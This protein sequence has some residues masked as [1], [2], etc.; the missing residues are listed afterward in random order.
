MSDDIFIS[1]SSE[2][3]ERIQPIIQVLERRGWSVWWDEDIT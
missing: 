3:L 2:D 1:Y